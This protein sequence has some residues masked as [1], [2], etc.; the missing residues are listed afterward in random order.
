GLVDGAL[1][2]LAL[3]DELAADI[4]VGGLR[5][6]GEARDQAAL[7]KR[8]RI[9]TQD[10]TVLAGARLRFVGIGDQIAGPVGLLGHEGPFQTGGES[11]PATAAQPRGLHLI[12]DPVA[13]L[14]Q[15]PGRAI[16]MAARL[17]PLQ[18]PVEL[19]VDIGEDAIL[20]LEHDLS[21]L[22]FLPKTRTYS[23]SPPRA[24]ASACR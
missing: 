11:C 8:V 14:F 9:V 15:N 5:A 13:A 21:H 12:D 18:R 10:V 3:T 7:D 19:A 6:H 23:S 20:I 16:P 17:R 4:D 24:S 2:R 22:G 1:Q